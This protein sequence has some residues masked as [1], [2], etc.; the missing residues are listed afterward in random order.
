MATP[1]AAHISPEEYLERERKAEFRSEYFRGEM[2]AMSG[3][4]RWHGRIVTNLVRDLGQ[5]LRSRDCNVYSSELR[6]CISETGVY[7]YPDIVVTCGE[8]NFRDSTLDTLLNPVVIVE[9]LSTSTENYDR[10]A[11]FESYRSI[12]S[13]M[14][15]LMVAQDKTH[16]E[17]YTRQPNGRWLLADHS[18]PSTRMHLECLGIDLQLAD[19]YEKVSFEPKQAL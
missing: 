19:V 13:L 15:Y 5:Q 12:P 4:T 16:L 10:G 18:D 7:A 17:Q 14:E 1:A 3:A 2:V 6:V 8:E 11:E 9:V